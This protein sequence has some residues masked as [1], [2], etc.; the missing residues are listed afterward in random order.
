MNMGT[1]LPDCPKCAAAG[2]KHTEI[3]VIVLP[4]KGPER[5]DFACSACGHGWSVLE[6]QKPA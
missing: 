6:P 5:T 4:R 3:V 1:A 2:E